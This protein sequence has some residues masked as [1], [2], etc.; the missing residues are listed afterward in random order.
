M[1]DNTLLPSLV[2]FVLTKHNDVYHPLMFQL[3][4]LQTFVLST[5]ALTCRKS[6]YVAT[7]PRVNAQEI[8]AASVILEHRNESSCVRCSHKDNVLMGIEEPTS[9]EEYEVIMKQFSSTLKPRQHQSAQRFYQII[10]SH[11]QTVISLFVD[12]LTIYI[13]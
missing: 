7:S 1:L 6:Q 11:D 3:L 9:Q 5:K 10:V 13:L 4:L 2:Y 8:I 12:N